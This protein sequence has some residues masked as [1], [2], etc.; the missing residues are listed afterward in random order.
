MGPRSRCWSA[1]ALRWSPARSPRR[2]L[3]ARRRRLRSSRP[4]RRRLAVRP[5]RGRPNR[6]LPRPLLQPRVAGAPAVGSLG[7]WRELWASLFASGASSE[8][9]QCPLMLAGDRPA[10][11]RRRPSPRRELRARAAQATLPAPRMRRPTCWG[12]PPMTTKTDSLVRERFRLTL[13]HQPVDRCPIDLGGTPQSTVESPATVAALAKYL[14]FAGPA[15]ADYDKFDRRILEHW[16]VD[17]RRAGALVP[18]V[19]ERSQRVS[20]TEH[21]DAYGIR[22]RFG[23]VYWEIA[24][25]PLRNATKDDVVAYELPTIAQIPAGVLDDCEARARALFHDTPCVVVGEHPV[26]GVLALACWLCGYDHILLMLAMDSEF[27]HRLF[28]KILEFQ[29]TVIRVYYG[30]L[31]PFLHLTTSGDDFGT[32]HGPF[33]SPPRWREFVKPYMRDRIDY[34]A[35]FTD[36]VY[37]HHPC[38]AVSALIPDLIQIGVRILNPI[39]PAG[40][41]MAPERLKAA[42]GN[43]IVFHGGL[44][45]QEGLPSGDPLLIRQAVENLLAAMHPE[46]DGGFIFAPAHN[47]QT[48]VSPASIAAMYDAVATPTGH[49]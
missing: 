7:R 8:T 35:R 24:E 32:Q 4:S 26:F 27:I 33:M 10:V 5:D 34:T 30:R 1:G 2:F 9:T 45:T 28:A 38:G 47:L 17:F 19:T 37:M 39:Q 49:A 31:G 41:G 3:G 44:D 18:F 20:E 40:A 48:D 21:V 16:D 13:A 25:G 42:H 46:D 29:K 14:G 15:P 12:T 11:D 22:H 36:A 23:G 6:R 43:E